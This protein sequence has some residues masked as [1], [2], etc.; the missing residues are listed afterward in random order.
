MRKLLVLSL[1]L[2]VLSACSSGEDPGREIQLTVMPLELTEEVASFVEL[3]EEIEMTGTFTPTPTVLPVTSVPQATSVPRSVSIRN[4]SN[5]TVRSDLPVYTVATGDTL[6]NIASRYGTT[7]NQLSEFNCLSDANLISAG[8]SL[9]V[10]GS[11]I[12]AV[13]SATPTPAQLGVRGTLRIFPADTF[14]HPIHETAYLLEPQ[15]PVTIQWRGLQANDY[16]GIVSVRF[17]LIAENGSIT[18]I[19]TDNN[20]SDGIAITWTAPD[21]AAGSIYASAR[22]GQN[23]FMETPL[24]RVR[25]EQTPLEDDDNSNNEGGASLGIRGTLGVH[26]AEH[27]GPDWSNYYIEPGTPITVSWTGI[28]PEYYY[29][30][31]SVTFF[32]VPDVGASTQLAVDNDMSDGMSYTWTPRAGVSGSITGNAQ[33]TNGDYWISSTL[34]ISEQETVINDEGGCQFVLSETANAYTEKDTASTVVASDIAAGTSYSI[35][36][37]VIHNETQFIKVDVSNAVQGWILGSKGSLNCP[38]Q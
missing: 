32:F 27:F 26:P 24:L 21:R 3:T 30:I 29:D 4:T 15:T 23:A 34:H 18:E 2:S 36:D 14:E 28:E 25:V 37:L 20:V 31:V 17:V 22:T 5:C 19:G 13:A 8:M 16:R 11:Q 6:S 1:I 35:I 12:S 10:P 38:G 9:Y 7:A 33:T